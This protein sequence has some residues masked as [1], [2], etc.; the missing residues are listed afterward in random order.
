MMAI[1]KDQLSGLHL[2]G[3][4]I[5]QNG[6]VTYLGSSPEHVGRAFEAPGAGVFDYLHTSDARFG[7]IV[8]GYSAT[9]CTYAYSGGWC[10][11]PQSSESK[12]T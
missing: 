2:N 12:S 10:R 6:W 11:D 5:D 7:L 8:Y 1:R 4:K 3:A 9:A